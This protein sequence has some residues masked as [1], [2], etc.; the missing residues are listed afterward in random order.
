MAGSGVSRVAG[1]AG[2]LALPDRDSVFESSNA[3]FASMVKVLPHASGHA[4]A[5]SRGGVMRRAGVLALCFVLGGL[6]G[7]SRVWT[8]AWNGGPSWGEP[9]EEVLPAGFFALTMCCCIFLMPGW[10]SHERFR[11]RVIPWM[12]CLSMV[13]LGWFFA[14]CWW[15]G[16]GLIPFA[17]LTSFV[18]FGGCV[19]WFRVVS[20]R[21]RSRVAAWGVLA[22]S[23]VLPSWG[24][25]LLLGGAWWSTLL[26]CVVI[27]VS[28]VL[29]FLQDLWVIDYCAADSRDAR[30]EWCAAWSLAIDIFLLIVALIGA[31]D[32]S[33]DK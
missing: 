26:T 7:L 15:Y 3:L 22:L 32:S 11:L 5:F 18:V 14:Q 1:G 33:D 21:V 28:G 4:R 23:C 17:L 6:F 19:S 31:G 24:L 9:R 8:G 30:Y 25:C 10:G 29:Y 12:A 16:S 13:F 20:D 2:S 27:G